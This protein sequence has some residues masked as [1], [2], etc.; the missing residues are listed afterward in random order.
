MF[1][2]LCERI[3]YDCKVWMPNRTPRHP[4]HCG[5][6]NLQ[7]G[8]FSYFC[9]C[10]CFDSVTKNGIFAFNGIC[11]RRVFTCVREHW[12]CHIHNRNHSNVSS[13]ACLPIAY[14]WHYVRVTA[15]NTHLMKRNFICAHDE[16]SRDRYG[17]LFHFNF[18][19]IFLF[20]SRSFAI[21]VYIIQRC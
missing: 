12:T 1:R 6:A 20:I 14:R 2:W 4:T 3:V 7:V 16:R 15:L 19:F 13:I 11:M 5:V 21:G 17:I 9:V 18:Y 8:L 10:V